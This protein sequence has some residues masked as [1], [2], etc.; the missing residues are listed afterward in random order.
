VSIEATFETTTQEGPLAALF[1]SY[2]D[3]EIRLDRVVPTNRVVIPYVWVRNVPAAA[4][5]DSVDPPG[6]EQLTQV[7]EVEG[8][9]FVRIDWDFDHESILTAVLETEATLV[10]AI[11]RNGEWRFQIRGEGH[12]EITAFHSYCRDHDLDL[13]L[14]SL[15]ELAPLV[16][17][18][19]YDL[20]EAQ[21]DALTL[22]YT[23]GYFDSP[24]QHTQAEL[25]DELGIT[26]Q[27]FGA[28]LRRG[29]NRLIG[30]TLVQQRDHV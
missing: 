3:A 29:L 5:D 19:L 25:A 24:R 13:E 11:G 1:T 16:G 6:V 27:A 21:R 7:D 12:E 9:A 20:T 23:C 15:H 26:R 18:G 22:A 8:D 28:R 4:F 17:D 30:E 10:S 2:P 14:V